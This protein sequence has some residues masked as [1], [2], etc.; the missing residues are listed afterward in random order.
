[1]LKITLGVWWLHEAGHSLNVLVDQKHL[2]NTI[3]L[4]L[5][6]PEVPKVFNHLTYTLLVKRSKYKQ[7][8]TTT[9]VCRLNS[10]KLKMGLAGRLFFAFENKPSNVKPF[11]HEHYLCCKHFIENKRIRNQQTDSRE[12]CF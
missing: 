5:S 10:N 12:E 8:N 3:N 2:R 9:Q 4:K 7:C 11:L 1:M 6:K